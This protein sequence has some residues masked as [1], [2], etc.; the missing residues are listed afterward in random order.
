MLAIITIITIIMKII[1]IMILLKIHMSRLHCW[2]FTFIM[3]R[4]ESCPDEEV[5]L[6]YSKNMS[7]TVL[8]AGFKL[9]PNCL[10]EG[11]HTYVFT[12]IQ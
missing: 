2:R 8:E 11:C 5:G 12:W 6:I 7:K 9:R 3:S 4:V 10:R 1:K